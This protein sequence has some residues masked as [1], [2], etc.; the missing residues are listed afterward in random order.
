MET[1]TDQEKDQ[2][3]ADYAESCRLGFIEQPGC[4]DSSFAAEYPELWRIQFREVVLKGVEAGCITWERI[5]EVAAEYRRE[6]SDIAELCQAAESIAGHIRKPMTA[7]EIADAL[8]SGD[9]NAE[10]ILQHLL[11]LI[12]DQ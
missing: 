5:A 8:N 7:R 3:L 2:I 6:R 1:M 9:Y 10:L 11:R 12:A 4:L